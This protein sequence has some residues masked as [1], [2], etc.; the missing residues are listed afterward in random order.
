LNNEDIKYSFLKDHRICV[1]FQ[2]DL[3]TFCAAARRKSY[4]FISL[5]RNRQMPSPLK[6]NREYLSAQRL[7]RRIA[8]F[9]L[10]I[11]IATCAPVAEAII[12]DRDAALDHAW[13]ETANLSAGFEEQVRATLN[14]IKGAM[15]FLK[16]RIEAEGATF[17]F[18]DWR[19][20]VPELV[21]PTINIVLVDTEGKLLRT[22]IQRAPNSVSYADRD[23]FPA[24][25]DNPNL[26]FFIGQP[27]IGKITKRLL[28]PCSLRLETRDG[29][30]AGV[31]VF[32]LD[33]GLLTTLYQRIN[34]GKKAAIDL[35]RTDGITLARFTSKKG[36]DAPAV[37]RNVQGIRALTDAQFADAGG[38]YHQSTFDGVPRLFHSRPLEPIG[39]N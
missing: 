39:Y 1:F 3:R 13:I 29:Y 15:E 7:K 30:F 38:Y 19:S 12:R 2:F 11:M 25:R 17:D 26:G 20:Q 6:P 27:H 21:D 37:G 22:S 4:A 23:Y 36:L 9:C 8:V 28:I 32:S 31:L 34:P 10:A 18:A 5:Q 14:S 16:R 35:F 33:P 24:Q